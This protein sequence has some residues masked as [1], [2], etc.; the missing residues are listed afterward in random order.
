MKPKATKVYPREAAWQ[1]H[2]D[3]GQREQLLAFVE[4][5][6]HT[7]VEKVRRNEITGDGIYDDVRILL[8]DLPGGA[9]QL[10]ATEQ[11]MRSPPE[12]RARMLQEAL[13]ELSHRLP[14]IPPPK[15]DGNGK[16]KGKGGQGQGQGQPTPQPAPNPAPKPASARQQTPKQAKQEKQETDGSPHLRERTLDEDLWFA[17]DGAQGHMGGGGGAQFLGQQRDKAVF[18]AVRELWEKL[19]IDY[20]HAQ[21]IDEGS[22][23]WSVPRIFK[24]RFNVNYVRHAKLDFART[25]DDIYLVLDTSGS[26][27]KFTKEIAAMAAASAG[28]VHLYHGTEARPQFAVRKATPL[29]FPGDRFPEWENKETES[30]FADRAA[31]EAFAQRFDEQHGVWNSFETQL[32]WWLRLEKPA[33]GSRLIFWGDTQGVGFLKPRV[34]RALVRP[35]KFCWLL[36]YPREHTVAEHYVRA[37]MRHQGLS[38]SREEWVAWAVDHPDATGGVE[39]PKLEGVGLPVLFDI[40]D[41]QG[42]RRMLQRLQTIK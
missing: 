42:I 20:D 40:S 36:P 25:V 23:K 37:Q 14:P 33:P 16:G 22:E 29:R 31:W 4:S 9:D 39:Y 21:P 32:A 30:L 12:Q 28:I 3:E 27:H 15:Q 35:Y 13:T 8:D 17:E 38:H 11:L 2:L 18:Y 41:G 19:A 1:G 24:S 5:S 6:R 7:L 10:P 26:V 34:L